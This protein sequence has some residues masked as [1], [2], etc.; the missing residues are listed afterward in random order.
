M[1]MRTREQMIT[2]MIFARMWW[3]KLPITVKRIRAGVEIIMRRWTSRKEM[4]RTAKTNSPQEP[5]T[6]EGFE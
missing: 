5:Q 1:K 6:I 3:W 4:T 2:R